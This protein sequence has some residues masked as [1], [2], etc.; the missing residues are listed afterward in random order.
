MPKRPQNPNP[1]QAAIDF[2]APAEE[3]QPEPVA[4]PIAPD[5]ETAAPESASEPP[6]EYSVSKGWVDMAGKQRTWRIHEPSGTKIAEIT[7]KS[8]AKRITDLLNRAEGG[9]DRSK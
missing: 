7:T 8:G 6:P 4:A 1:Y 9:R 5:S 3:L 2:A